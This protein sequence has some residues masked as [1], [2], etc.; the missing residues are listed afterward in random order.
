MKQQYE[1]EGKEEGEEERS[2]KMNIWL[3]IINGNVDVKWI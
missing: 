3:K 2:I 1:G